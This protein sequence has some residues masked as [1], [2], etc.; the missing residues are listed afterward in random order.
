MN[1]QK[2]DI[3]LSE[4]SLILL[5]NMILPSLIHFFPANS[6]TSFFFMAKN[7]SIV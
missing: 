7:N 4:T 5:I 2:H 1:E 3:C 6:I